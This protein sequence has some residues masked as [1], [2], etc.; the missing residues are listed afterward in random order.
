MASNATSSTMGD[1][2][3]KND[4]LEPPPN[5]D[6]DVDG[7]D[8][9]GKNPEHQKMDL[10]PNDLVDWSAD[11]DDE[12][13]DG[14]ASGGEVGEPVSATLA[15]KP[16][17]K[18]EMEAQQLRAKCEHILAENR[19][20]GG[21]IVGLRI[22]LKV[23]DK[24][25]EAPRSDAAKFIAAEKEAAMLQERNRWLAQKLTDAEAET[26][27][28]RHATSTPTTW[29]AR[30]DSW[31]SAD[32]TRNATVISAMSVNASEAVVITAA[33]RT[34]PTRAGIILNLKV[35]LESSD[36]GPGDED[37]VMQ[38]AVPEVRP[39]LPFRDG[40]Y[41]PDNS[42]LREV[43]TEERQHI[44]YDV[45]PLAPTTT[46]C[47]LTDDPL[48]AWVQNVHDLAI[49]GDR[50]MAGIKCPFALVCTARQAADF[51]GK[52]SFRVYHTHSSPCTADLSHQKN[53]ELFSVSITG[54]ILLVVGLDNNSIFFHWLGTLK[55]HQRYLSSIHSTLPTHYGGHNELGLLLFLELG[56][57]RNFGLLVHFKLP[58][59]MP[60][61][62]KVELREKYLLVLFRLLH[63]PR[64]GHTGWRALDGC[65]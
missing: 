51:D 2:Q 5:V 26:A 15:G 55:T 13:D 62:L 45:P 48:G 33:A 23:T 20:L 28:P 18:Y 3:F 27:S 49:R 25:M 39:E 35:Q 21:E 31:M 63:R 60:F 65:V 44:G 38:E 53:Y 30:V 37:M 36:M 7:G 6:F 54:I 24:L 42:V 52:S 59:S 4:L 40:R 9:L 11:G 17:Q 12:I 19:T 43:A 50:Q 22:E 32:K 56:Q 47:N 46:D 16:K 1:P 58:E 14:V 29:R 57:R 41:I 10:D 64:R 61:E 34:D 8:I